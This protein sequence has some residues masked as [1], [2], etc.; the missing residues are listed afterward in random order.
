[1]LVQVQ[2]QIVEQLEQQLSKEQSR[3]EA[4]M[5]HLKAVKEDRGGLVEPEP[6][7]APPLSHL[8]FISAYS[9][10]V[11]PAPGPARRRATERANS[12]EAGERGPPHRHQEKVKIFRQIESSL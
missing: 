4:M 10:R 12:V 1:M 2:I 7:P 3:L 9:D 6:R 11:R 5:D 8:T